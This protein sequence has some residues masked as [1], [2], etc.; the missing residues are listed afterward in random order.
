[1]DLLTQQIE[2]YCNRSQVKNALGVKSK[3][4]AKFLAQGEYNINY[5]L[6]LDGQNRFVFR[7]NTASQLLLDNQIAYEYNALEALQASGVTPT[8]LFLDDTKDDFAYGI[9]I[10]NYLEG[11]PLNYLTDLNI[12]AKLFAKIHSLPY[13]RFEH[14]LIKEEGLCSARVMEGTRW[15]VD[16][17]QCLKAPLAIKRIL[18]NL[19]EYC[20]KHESRDQDFERNPWLVVNNTE[21]NSHN[22]IIGEQKQYII[23]WEKPVI[24]DPVQDITQFLAP[25]TTLWKSPHRLTN[26]QIKDFYKAYALHSDD[27]ASTLEERVNWYK[28]FLYLRALSWCA[29]AWVSYQD[30]TRI[31]QNRQTYLTIETYL[32]EQFLCDLLADYI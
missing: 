14:L 31:I 27:R 15:L 21:V 16:Y 5:V 2:N 12:A 26:K 20:I 30:A 9:L 23:D 18:N 24:S 10:M 29:N 11:R 8:P 3:L 17:N 28:P 32:T 4:V 6:M 22:F 19:L 13:E 1:M 7:M 25:T